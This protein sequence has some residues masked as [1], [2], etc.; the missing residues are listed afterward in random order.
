MFKACLVQHCFLLQG[1][2]GLFIE[3]KWLGAWTDPRC[4]QQYMSQEQTKA[5]PGNNSQG[6]IYKHYVRYQSCGAHPCTELCP[7]HDVL[8]QDVMNVL[9]DHSNQNEAPALKRPL[10]CMDTHLSTF[11]VVLAGVAGDTMRV[12][13]SLVCKSP[14]WN[15]A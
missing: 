9:P 14:D 4:V 15:R 5:S 11:A 6:A 10:S 12:S 2:R 13:P 7:W 3:D 8:C 1:L